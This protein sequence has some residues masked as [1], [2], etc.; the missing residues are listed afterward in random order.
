MLSGSG[1]GD[2]AGLGGSARG[3]L[4]RRG[5][6]GAVA[7]LA[8]RLRPYAADK[9]LTPSALEAIARMMQERIHFASEAI[10]QS[11]FLFAP[12]L[13]Y[14]DKPLK[15]AWKAHTPEL[16]TA[17]SDAL[18]RETDFTSE[19]L[20]DFLHQ[21]A[22]SR[23]VGLGAVMLPVRLALTGAGGGPSLF[24][25]MAF[26]GKAETINRISMAFTQMPNQ[27]STGLVSGI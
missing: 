8:E 22:E 20:N 9:N 1:V 15:K 14:E 26:L 11:S 4:A 23:Q 3:A 7:E 18:E 6:G 27:L 5:A 24:E 10:E 19:H 21:F 13:R 25:I 16:L 17:F 2:R 12:P